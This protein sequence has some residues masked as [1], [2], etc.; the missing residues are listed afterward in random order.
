MAEIKLLSNE[1]IDK[2][3]AGEVVEK[4][5]N[6]VKE[7]LENSLDAGAT[8]IVCE[9]K[10]G[11]IDLIR[12]TDNGKGIASDDCTNAFLRHATSKIHEIEDLKD[13]NTLGFRGE[14]LSS[15]AAVSKTELITKTRDSL[16][17]KK[18]NINGGVLMEDSDV[19]APNGT[20]II[21]RQ[22][23]YNTPA[24]KKFLKSAAAEAATIQDLVEKIALSNPDVAVSLL[25]NNKIKVDSPGNGKEGDAIYSVFGKDVYRALLPLDYESE[26]IHITGFI[27]KPEFNYQ[28]RNGEIY[29]VNGR[30][31]RSKT[32]Q[33]G[34]EEGFSGFLM[35]HRFPFCI[36]N[37]NIDQE[38]VDVNVHPR[39]MEVRF[40]DDELIKKHIKYS[41][42]ETLSKTELIPEVSV[43]FDLKTETDSFD[44]K[45]NTDALSD[46]AFDRSF[47]EV[48]DEDVTFPEHEVI[49]DTKIDSVN[50]KKVQPFEINRVAEKEIIFNK[51]LSELKPV[52][53]SLFD[54]KLIT[55]E[56]LKRYRIIGQVFNTYWLITLDDDLYIVDQHAAHEKVNYEKF[57]RRFKEDSFY[58]QTL[59]SPVILN[60]S[61]IEK[62]ALS[63][64]YDLF[65]RFGFELE[66]FGDSSFALRSVPGDMF[67][68]DYSELFH[69]ILNEL[70]DKGS[71]E[72]PE[73][74]LDK[75]A[76]KAC[77][78]S[79]KGGMSISFGE[80][81]ELMNEMM[82]L[83]NPYNCP[84]GRPTF[85]KITKNELEHKFK[86]IV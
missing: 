3:A 64:N 76:T 86:R 45:I 81:E 4:P 25:I 59:L 82:K 67:E 30:Y 22:L 68:M 20:T 47:Y 32:I 18:I 9:I 12:V 66:E 57:L 72:V 85:I 17:G 40:S 26:G 28:S 33:T 23:F 24:R 65:T 14:A 29:F 84:H 11:G 49:L 36:L 1:T 71:S 69:D 7:L 15:I 78:A 75:L 48:K 56:P 46:V 34:I 19:G 37:I 74:F 43:D 6:V 5:V 79:V 13:L 8:R 62:E 60:L 53:E 39:K 41:I 21:I 31:I 51:E 10:N 52:D 35:Q 16:L 54:K 77:K 63:V 61:P 50:E 55:D 2:I 58:G 80:M 42:I 27:C 73:V 70:S 83:D 38:N 44:F